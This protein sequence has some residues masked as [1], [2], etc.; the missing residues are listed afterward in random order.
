MRDECIEAPAAKERCASRHAAGVEELA[1]QVE[2]FKIVLAYTRRFV[3]GKDVPAE[4]PD[5]DT[6]DAWKAVG[7]RA[8]D[9]N[10]SAQPCLDWRG[11]SN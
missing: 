11:H 4:A 2:R 9:K 7:K 5:N 10:R 8:G 3:L 6:I 1:E